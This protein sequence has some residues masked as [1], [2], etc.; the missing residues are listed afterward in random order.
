MVETNPIKLQ[1]LLIRI[2]GEKMKILTIVGARPQFIK[3]AVV[4]RA[5]ADHNKSSNIRITEKSARKR[6]FLRAV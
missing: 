4:S 3:A 2:K 5:I 1:I 6:R